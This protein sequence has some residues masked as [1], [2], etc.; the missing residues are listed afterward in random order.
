[1]SNII[2][3]NILLSLQN[4]INNDIINANPVAIGA[5]AGQTSQGMSSVAIGPSTGN[6]SQGTYAIAI[7]S[8]AGQ[9][10]QSSSAIAIG[11]N[12]GNSSQ[13]SNA[14][15]IGINAGHSNQTQDAI[16]IGNAAGNNTQGSK[17]IAIG[18]SAGATSQGTNSVAIGY[19][20]G[21]SAQATGTVAIGQAAGST[22]QDSYAIAIGRNAGNTGQGA[23]SI[24]IGYNA[25]Y[26][27]QAANSIILNATGTT[28]NVTGT[29][30]FVNPV[31][32]DNYSGIRA[33]YL[34]TDNEIRASNNKT[35]IISHPINNDKYLVHACLEGPEAGI[36]YRGKATITNNE[37][38]K[39]T[40]PDYV[41]YIGS[42]YTI[43][44]T[45]IFSG[46]KTNEQYETSEIEDNSF[47]VYG[48]NGSFYWVV[49]AEREK[50][51]VE[52][53]ISDVKI[54]GNG[55]YKYIN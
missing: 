2:R 30:F 36:Y 51:E 28:V 41:K 19:N 38:I 16:A 5:Y 42:N 1:M 25:G 54:E 29:G 49:F 53:N 14:V 11:S 12:T 27:N 9:T 3:D 7:G 44:I 46:K 40:L 45:R 8:N 13:G 48:P 55:P 17:S 31:T 47:T 22:T 43:N 4:Q 24:A 23:N 34:T 20:A 37:Y 52:P 50:I 33:L 39:I 6:S 35:F 15:A 18:Y 21:Y 10:S 32:I 26:T